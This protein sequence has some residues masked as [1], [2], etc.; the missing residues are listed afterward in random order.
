[1]HDTDTKPRSLS[2]PEQATSVYLMT[3]AGT[4]LYTSI[5]TL[6]HDASLHLILLLFR[7]EQPS[8]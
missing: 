6:G 3:P 7:S 2:F 5:A 1:M 8:N 4:W